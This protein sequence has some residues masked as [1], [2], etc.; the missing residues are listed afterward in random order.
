MN[1]A[2]VYA[3]ISCETFWRE[4]PRSQAVAGLD[5]TL[6]LLWPLADEAVSHGTLGLFLRMAEW[7]RA[8]SPR[9]GAHYES[10]SPP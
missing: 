5:E 6:P 8:Q 9:G 3:A 7:V 2:M 10:C 1:G 4:A